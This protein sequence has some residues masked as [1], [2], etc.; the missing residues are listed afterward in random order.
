MHDVIF[1]YLFKY[2]WKKGL[3]NFNTA[4][5]ETVMDGS[6]RWYNVVIRYEGEKASHRL[7]ILIRRDLYM[8]SLL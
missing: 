8:A 5:I 3:F 6:S 7:T 4:D 1:C 2:A